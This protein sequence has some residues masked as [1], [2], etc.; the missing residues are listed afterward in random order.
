VNS[1]EIPVFFVGETPELAERLRRCYDAIAWDPG[2]RMRPAF[3]SIPRAGAGDLLPE[4]GEGLVYIETLR[5]PAVESDLA[6]EVRRRNP[7]LQ[8]VLLAE[9]DIDYFRVAQECRIGNILKKNRFD[10]SMVRA[11][12]VR[13][14]T[15]N[16]FGFDPYFPDGYTAGPLIRTYAGTVEIAGVIADSADFFRDS[17][18]EALWPHFRM[19]LHELLTNTFAYAIEGIA[20][21]DRDQNAT[22][23]QPRLFIAE[24]RGIKVSLAADAEKVGV[25]VQDS[26][27]NLSLLRV[28]D[29]LRR[30]SRIGDEKIPPGLL[31][32][33][34]RGISLVYRYSRFIINILQGVRTETIF[35]QYHREELNRYESIIVTEVAP[36]QPG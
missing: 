6:R 21:E 7:A 14:L 30:Q 24:R 26:T 12:S 29:K 23:P 18:P 5:D 28:L 8:I 11:L 32:E 16:I 20:A 31:D 33:T 19:F 10:G 17:V 9:D 27:G 25:S 15:G 13:L 36:L 3:R 2:Y 4:R 1:R 34:G 35:L 22:A